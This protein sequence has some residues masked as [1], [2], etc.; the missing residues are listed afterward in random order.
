MGLKGTGDRSVRLLSWSPRDSLALAGLCPF[1]RGEL[2][3]LTHSTSP[4]S[5]PGLQHHRMEDILVLPKVG[6]RCGTLRAFYSCRSQRMGPDGGSL[7]LGTVLSSALSEEV[8]PWTLSISCAA[9][10]MV[11]APITMG[12]RREVQ[13]NSQNWL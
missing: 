8:L 4:E 6:G 10:K 12:Q 13:A 1:D 7:C 2:R 3:P 5:L 11:S 9:P